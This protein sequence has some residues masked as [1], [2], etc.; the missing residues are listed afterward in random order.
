[1]LVK[2]KKVYY[3]GYCKKHGLSGGSMAR[4]EKICTLNINRVCHWNDTW[5]SY[6]RTSHKSQPL[7]KL[8]ANFKRIKTIKAKHIDNLREAVE[9]CPACMLTVIRC[10]GR[11]TE[12]Y[13]LFEYSKEVEEF[14]DM[15]GKE[16]QEAEYQS[17]MREMI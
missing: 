14:N 8:L 17:M 13:G 16:A 2:E 11:G 3:C 4:H 6:D 5:T 12:V 7:P 15:I 1:M 9:Y 10:A